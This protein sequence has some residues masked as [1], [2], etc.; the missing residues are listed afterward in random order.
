V[1]KKIALILFSLLL[2]LAPASLSQTVAKD[3]GSFGPSLQKSSAPAFFPRNWIRGYT[4]FAVAPSHNEPDLGRCMFP[5]PAGAGGAA[6]QCTAYARSLLS[7]YLEV[8]PLGHTP[9]RHL[10]LFFEP[11]FSFGRNIPQVRYTASM[12]PIAYERAWGAG[13]ELPLNLQ[14]RLTQHQV[15]YLGRY[16]NSLGPADLH[17]NGSY[18]LYTTVSVRWSFGGYGRNGA[19]SA[20]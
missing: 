19:P 17:T 7:G 8:Q 9:A 13:F 18:G 15:D 2:F 3:D 11:R 10:F 4:D 14:V 12:E 16:G 20:Y 5:Q 1:V 6:S